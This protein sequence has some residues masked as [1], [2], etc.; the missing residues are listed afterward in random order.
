MIPIH[1][2]LSFPNN[3]ATFMVAITAVSNRSHSLKCIY[4]H[5]ISV[6]GSCSFSKSTDGHLQ[7]REENTHPT[8]WQMPSRFLESSAASTITVPT[9][10]S[11]FPSEKAWAKSYWYI[12]GSYHRL[13][14]PSTDFSKLGS[15]LI[16]PASLPVF[17]DFAG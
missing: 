6:T 3:L 9:F 16:A 14:R 15:N 7:A 12:R 17:L 11:R 5:H 8:P 1:P 13:H 2:T 4:T 10:L